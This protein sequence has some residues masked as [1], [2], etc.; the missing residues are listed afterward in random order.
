MT[1]KEKILKM[2][3]INS[4]YGFK[5]KDIE[6]IYMHWNNWVCYFDI[7]LYRMSKIKKCLVKGNLIIQN[8][9][10]NYYKI[11]YIE[12]NYIYWIGK[13]IYNMIWKNSDEK[14]AVLIGW[15]NSRVWLDI[16]DKLCWITGFNWC[17]DKKTIH[18]KW[19]SL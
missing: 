16:F 3:D 5:E 13:D 17:I 11:W 14:N 8:V 4:T 6:K 7:V 2:Y 15:S 10:W 12:K 9:W 19:L 1:K 18:Q